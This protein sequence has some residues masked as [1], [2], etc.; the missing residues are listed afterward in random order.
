VTPT[1]AEIRAAFKATM[2][3][4]IPDLTVYDIVPDTVNLP[5]VYVLPST[6]TY[7]FSLRAP[8]DVWIFDLNVLVSKGDSEIA[9][10][11]LDEFI[12]SSGDNSIRA[13]VLRFQDLGLQRRGVRAH[14]TGM[15]GYGGQFAAAGIDNIGAT[16]RLEVTLTVRG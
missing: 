3:V 5:C 15:S 2:E 1:L 13:A 14:I 7:D 9:Q 12:S 8:E 16:L 4:A 6:A 10:N 11:T